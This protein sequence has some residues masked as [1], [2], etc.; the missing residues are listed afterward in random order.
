MTAILARRAV[1]PRVERVCDGLILEHVQVAA[2]SYP[3]VPFGHDRS[4]HP[5]YA[6]E[7]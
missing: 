4:R 5:R 1:A 2:D 6:D 7:E 3:F